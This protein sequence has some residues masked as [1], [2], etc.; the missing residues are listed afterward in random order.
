MLPPPHYRKYIRGLELLVI[1]NVELWT[2]IT[3]LD[4]KALFPLID[5]LKITVDCNFSNASIIPI[6]IS[7]VTELPS[8]NMQSL[9]LR[10]IPLPPFV[11]PGRSR[12]EIGANKFIRLK[13]MKLLTLSGG[14]L[15]TDS[16]SETVSGGVF[17]Q[18]SWR[19]K[20]KILPNSPAHAS[21]LAGKE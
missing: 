7:Q 12:I 11:L 1:S 19:V 15:H 8:F 5:S 17:V 3:N 13:M 14:T 4:L 10:F 20:N 21:L 2:H 16:E 18:R 9:E 6:L